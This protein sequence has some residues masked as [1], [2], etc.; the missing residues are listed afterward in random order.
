MNVVGN[1]IDCFVM[2]VLVVTCVLGFALAITS[3]NYSM[4]REAIAECEAKLPRNQHCVLTAIP[5]EQN[6]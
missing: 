3:Y 1:F 5:E 6:Q 2:G 4:S